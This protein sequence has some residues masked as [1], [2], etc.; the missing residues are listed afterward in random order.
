MIIN[1]EDILKDQV[2]EIE[3]IIRYQRSDAG[4]GHYPSQSSRDRTYMAMRYDA[5]TEKIFSVYYYDT[6]SNCKTFFLDI[7]QNIDLTIV[8]TSIS[9]TE[10][11][12][13]EYDLNNQKDFIKLVDDVKNFLTSSTIRQKAIRGVLSHSDV[14]R[15]KRLAEA[16]ASRKGN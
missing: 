6:S 8:V 16:W 14:S 2:P 10:S 15:S 5:F 11:E 7:M 1:I 4:Q 3:T 9:A 12:T 13:F